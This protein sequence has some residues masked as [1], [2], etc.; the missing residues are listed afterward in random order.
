MAEIT[1]KTLLNKILLRDKC[2]H[3]ALKR[4]CLAV[5]D[6]NL[7]YYSEVNMEQ[8][9]QLRVRVVPPTLRMAEVAA[10]H[11]STMLGHILAAHAIF[12]ATSQLW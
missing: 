7:Y 5:K 1:G 11:A 3:G 8:T 6:R 4:A 2:Y 9:R 10:F 12:E